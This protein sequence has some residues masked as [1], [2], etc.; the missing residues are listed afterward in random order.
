MSLQECA[1]LWPEHI[2]IPV[3]TV[4]VKWQTHTHKLPPD[5]QQENDGARKSAGSRHTLHVA[6]ARGIVSLGY[7]YIL[8]VY[9][10]FLIKSSGFLNWTNSTLLYFS[11][12]HCRRIYLSSSSWSTTRNR[13]RTRYIWVIQ[14]GTT[15]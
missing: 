9:C 1:E 15:L 3:P 14:S 7:N 10:S 5:I 6:S 11:F 13:G 8:N 4:S 12:L 2:S